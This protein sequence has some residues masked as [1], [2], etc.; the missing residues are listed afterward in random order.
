MTKWTGTSG[1]IFCASPPR[2]AM[3]SRIA[4]RS[5]TAGTPV[6][7]C[8]STRA[9]RYWIAVG[10][11]LLLPVDDRL[12]VVA[13][14]GDAVL[15]AKQI[16]EQHLHRQGQPRDVAELL[17]CFGEGVISVGLAADLERAAGVQ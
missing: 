15:E 17:A 16:L 9:G 12:D 1:L 7:S 13:G 2:L 6:K 4:A 3:S 11:A 10:A 5:T 14:D 8:I